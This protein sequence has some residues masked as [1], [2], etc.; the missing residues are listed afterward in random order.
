MSGEW[1]DDVG[2][3]IAVMLLLYPVLYHGTTAS[4]AFAGA[5]VHISI[6][7]SPVT[8]SDGILAAALSPL[9]V[10]AGHAYRQGVLDHV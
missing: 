10:Q 5:T 8:Q 7:R 6:R 2:H 9:V 1:K 4:P 3:A